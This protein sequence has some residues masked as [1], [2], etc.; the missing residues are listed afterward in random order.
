MVKFTGNKSLLISIII[1]L[2][3][4]FLLKIK[5]TNTLETFSN[6]PITD[7][8]TL[9]NNLISNV[10]TLDSKGFSDKLKIFTTGIEQFII[11]V[12]N[13]KDKKN[14]NDYIIEITTKI[15]E[16]ID[17]FKTIKNYITNKL[18]S[19]ETVKVGNKETQLLPASK[20]PASKA[21]ESAPAP[22]PAPG[23][24]PASQ[25]PGQTPASQ[26]PESAPAQAPASQAPGQAPASQAPAPAPAP[27]Q[28]PASQAPGQ[29]PASQAKADEKA[30]AEKAK[31]EAELKNLY[32][33]LDVINNVKKKNQN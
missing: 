3:L 24:A 6:T 7:L 29:A 13:T 26:A 30:A 31:L 10:N 32:K 22:A 20:A 5:K 23:Q 17:L 12:N 27:E 33:L 14:L 11:V 2:L 1:L 28:A 21:P 19:L 25:A 16:D 15:T 18:N 8:I 4:I 9:Y